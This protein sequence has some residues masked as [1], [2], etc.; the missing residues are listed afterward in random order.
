MKKCK[1][2]ISVK[3]QM[4]QEMNRIEKKTKNEIAT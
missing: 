1:F 4:R 3:D 2:R